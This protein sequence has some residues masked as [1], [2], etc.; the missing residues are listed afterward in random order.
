MFVTFQPSSDGKSTISSTNSDFSSSTQSESCGK[1]CLY[2]TQFVMVTLELLLLLD[3]DLSI[4]ILDNRGGISSH[5]FP[6]T[7]LELYAQEM[8]LVTSTK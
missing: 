2:L 6:I 3:L 4:I 8:L 7:P 5:I 1:K